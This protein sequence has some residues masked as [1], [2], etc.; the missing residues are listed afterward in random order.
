M[1]VHKPKIKNDIM[2]R[3]EILRGAFIFVPFV[4]V[5][6]FK[7]LF[8]HCS[9]FPNNSTL[10]K[11]LFFQ[12]SLDSMLGRKINFDVNKYCVFKTKIEQQWT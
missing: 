12:N 7:W 5:P 11:N 4:K 2:A 3:I 10:M 8:L 9:N 1:D 6:R